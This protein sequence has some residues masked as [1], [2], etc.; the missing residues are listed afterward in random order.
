MP[1]PGQA[2]PDPA[3]RRLD[4]AQFR[5]YVENA[6]DIIFTI[7]LD[8]RF[9]YVSP[10]WRTKLGHDPAQVV[11]QPL[12]TFLHPDD[13][14][15]CSEIV[16]RLLADGGTAPEA[17]PATAEYRVRHADGGWRWHA[18]NAG[19]IRGPDGGIVSVL[20]VARDISARKQAEQALRTSETRYRLLAENANDVIWTMALDGTVTYI[21]PS[22]E[23]VRGFTAEEAMAQTLEQTLLPD[24]Q[25][26]SIDYVVR[27][28]QAI[29]EGSDLPRH[30]SEMHYLRKDGS[31]MTADVIAL[32]LLD[33]EGR[34]V[35][36]L[37][38]S[39]DISELKR[40][41]AELRR[42]NDELRRHRDH[43]DELVAERTR[44]LAA[45][46]DAAESANRAKTAL[47]TNASHELRTPLNQIAGYAYLLESSLTDPEQRGQAETISTAA[48]QLLRLVG[49]MLDAARLEAGELR[50]EP[51][52][53][54]ARELAARALETVRPQAEAAG[55]RLAFAPAP[56]LPSRLLGDALRLG[57]VLH[58]LLDNAVK[59]SDAGCVRLGLSATAPSA[60]QAELRFEVEDQGIG[61]EPG[62]RRRLFQLFEQGDGSSTRRHGGTGIGLALCQRIVRLMGGTIGYEPREGGGSRFWFTVRLPVA[63]ES[64]RAP[65]A[66]APA[67]AL[68]EAAARRLE[69][70]LADDDLAACA[71]WGTVRDLLT[72]LLADDAGA[73]DKAIAGID[74][75]G[76]LEIL[77][78]HPTGPRASG[79]A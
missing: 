29:A 39:R 76:A 7:G 34:P 45:A 36:I 59:F 49:N 57:Q 75:A 20:G 71:L 12:T 5:A 69:N 48:G 60:G 67:R 66:E 19:P 10:N 6:N 13:L 58:H 37:G 73:L 21:S 54:D 2:A 1:P 44:E 23:R 63:R 46:R 4:D 30:R 79:Q 33:D 64:A 55:L 50:L 3:G 77:R 32:P 8:G 78:R 65:L 11:G 70:L 24:S 18:A 40:Q 9:H 56:G 17:E 62:I 51:N 38:V 42:V 15:R 31:I 74:L 14:E 53:F 28:H 35:G 72:P 43:L 68:A 52:V 61:I 16:Q 26:A 27:L 41:E 25:K 22:I 47:L